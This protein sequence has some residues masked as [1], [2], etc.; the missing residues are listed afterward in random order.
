[1][2]VWMEGLQYFIEILSQKSNKNEA[3][4]GWVHSRRKKH[5]RPP[6]PPLLP[7]LSNSTSSSFPVVLN[8][9][10]SYGCTIW[11]FLKVIWS[12]KTMEQWPK[13]FNSKTQIVLMCL[14]QALT[15]FTSKGYTLF[16][17]KPIWVIFVALDSL[18]WK[19]IKLC[20]T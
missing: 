7:V 6:K 10:D 1:M 11:S 15:P 9:L 3:K 17:S 13:N 16:I 8:Y 4:K 19:N 20:F 18:G 14:N 2:G 12:V 5:I